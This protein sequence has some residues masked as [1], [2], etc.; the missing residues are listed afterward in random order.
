MKLPVPLPSVVWE[1]E[2]VGFEEVLQ[3]TP[4]AVTDEL[5]CPVTFPPPVAVVSVILVMELVET[6]G[7]VPEPVV[8]KVTW[9]T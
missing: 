7:T 5:P 6:V 4:R 8:V 9:L 1:S 3:Q 2:I